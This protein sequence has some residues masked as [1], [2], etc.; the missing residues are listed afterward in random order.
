MVF[1]KDLHITRILNFPIED[2]QIVIDVDMTIKLEEGHCC[3]DIP[4]SIEEL[5]KNKQIKLNKSYDINALY[6]I[7]DKGDKYTLFNFSYMYKKDIHSHEYIS[8]I[9][10]SILYNAHIKC[11]NDIKIDKAEVIA[12]CEKAVFID[13]NFNNIHIKTEPQYIK[14]DLSSEEMDFL[15][16]DYKGKYAKNIK[17]AFCGEQTFKDAE[18]LMWILSEFSLLIYEDMFFYDTFDLYCKNK[19]YKLK[20]Y[21]HTNLSALRSEQLRTKNAKCKT[22]WY[23]NYKNLFAN[24]VNFREESGIIFDVFRSTIYSQSFREDYPLRLSQ[25][26]EGLANYLSLANTNKNDSFNTAIQISLY[27]NDY[28][29]EYLPKNSDIAEFAK[30]ITKHRNKFSHVKDKGEYLKGTENERYAEI[31]YTTIRVIIIK[32]IQEEL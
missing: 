20:S 16:D 25:T 28:I 18:S 32:H 7:D 3:C 19:N 6:A 15:G 29:K 17:I 5:I 22:I 2:S 9:Y 12:M 21:C 14:E 8:L 31:L 24:F 27:C 10:N 11:W 26:M 13:I 23:N 30:N 1:E 4:K